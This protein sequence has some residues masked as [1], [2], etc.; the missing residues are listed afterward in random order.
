MEASRSR[1]PTNARPSEDSLRRSLREQL[2]RGGV[3]RFACAA[4]RES[5]RSTPSS[6]ALNGAAHCD[7]SD[8]DAH[9]TCDAGGARAAAASGRIARVGTL[10]R[11]GAA[12][13]R[14]AEANRVCHG[15]STGILLGPRRAGLHAAAVTLAHRHWTFG[16]HGVA[17]CIR[18]D[19]CERGVRRLSVRRSN[20]RDVGRVV[21][22]ARVGRR[23]NIAAGVRCH[24]RLAACAE[25]T[26]DTEHDR[27]RA[28]VESPSK[29]HCFHEGSARRSD[30]ANS[31]RCSSRPDLDQ[32]EHHG[33][34][35]VDADDSSNAR[36]ETSTRRA[37]FV[38]A[39]L[40]AR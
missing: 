1:S 9:F 28:P 3:E 23:E 20:D 14:R 5:K 27:K 7:G 12:G 32:L 2:G 16:A 38:T 34:G 21:C 29:L 6:R 22:R 10:V 17:R 15:V 11:A 33:L 26:Y 18:R 25:R 30:A 24:D 37:R 31:E 4:S 36:P 40:I 39:T 8:R 13:L 35:V 19:V